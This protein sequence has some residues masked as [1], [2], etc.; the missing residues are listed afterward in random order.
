[1]RRVLIPLAAAFLFI[2]MTALPAAAWEIHASGSAVCLDDGTFQVSWAYAS[3]NAGE[4][5]SWSPYANPTSLPGSTS[6][7]ISNTALAVWDKGTADTGDDES[8]SDTATVTVPGGCVPTHVEH[9]PAVSGS[10]SCDL[11][12]PGTYALRFEVNPDGATS[13]DGLP[14]DDLAY[15]GSFPVTGSTTFHYSDGPDVTVEYSVTATET[16][17]TPTPDTDANTD[18]AA[19]TTADA[20]PDTDSDANPDTDAEPQPDAVTTTTPPPD[21]G[22]SGS[23]R[24]AW[25]QR[26]GIHRFAGRREGSGS[27]RVR[28]D[29]ARPLGAPRF[30]GRD[31]T[32]IG[33]RGRMVPRSR[34]PRP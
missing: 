26:D 8:D 20:D 4:V 33:G 28:P 30:E 6:G 11:E 32:A 14:V 21:A 3:T 29:R 31:A 12:K 10:A 19:T 27:G 18:T 9:H 25:V 5:V 1:M 17:S 23:P 2:G 7:S 15:A 16:C 24:R 22:A 13:I 34:R